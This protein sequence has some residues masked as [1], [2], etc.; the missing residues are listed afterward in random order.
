MVLLLP[1]YMLTVLNLLCSTCADDI[2][3][4]AHIAWGLCYLNST[5]NPFLY[6]LCNV[7]FRRAFCN[8]L[9]GR[10]QQLQ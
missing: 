10:F 4:P 1:F 3:W 2:S 9:T 7:N 5:V 8:I 6:A